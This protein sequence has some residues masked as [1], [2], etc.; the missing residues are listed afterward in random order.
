MKKRKLRENCNTATLA[1]LLSATLTCSSYSTLS[2]SQLL[3]ETQPEPHSFVKTSVLRENSSTFHTLKLKIHD[4]LR[5]FPYKP[6]LRSFRQ[7]IETG[8]LENR[9]TWKNLEKLMG[10]STFREAQLENIPCFTCFYLMFFLVTHIN[11]MSL[12]E[13]P[14]KPRFFEAAMPANVGH[15]NAQH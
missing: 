9:L 1:T 4:F 6:I 15:Q 12:T 7:V 14:R 10:K 3:Y 2:Y 8:R 5:V 13:T 11:L